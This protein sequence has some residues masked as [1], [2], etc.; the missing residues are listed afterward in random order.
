MEIDLCSMT[1]AELLEWANSLNPALTFREDIDSFSE[2][3]C[4]IVGDWKGPHI[5]LQAGHR[6]RPCAGGGPYISYRFDS[7]K[8]PGYEGCAGGYDDLDRLARHIMLD[9]RR[10]NLL[11]EQ[12]RLF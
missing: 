4:A 5:A 10:W 7:M 12:P 9:A 1:N 3:P 11:D 2:M 6:F 8:A